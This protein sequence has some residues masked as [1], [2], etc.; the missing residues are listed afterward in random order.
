MNSNATPVRAS[1]AR[2]IL[3]IYLDLIVFSVPWALLHAFALRSSPDLEKLSTPAKF[4]TFAVLE[5][6]LHRVVRWSP[7]TWLLAIRPAE[8]VV[9]PIIKS[10]E[11]WFTL[12]AGVL[13]L[14]EGSKGLVRWTMWTPPT[15]MFG[16]RLPAEIWPLIAMSTG[17]VECWIAYLIFRTRAAAAAVALPYFGAILVSVFTSWPLWDAWVAESISRR[18]AYQGAAIRPG[19]IEQ[20]QALS[21]EIILAGPVL[22]L[23]LTLAATFLFAR[24]RS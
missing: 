10:R 9:D 11:H 7:G 13:L 3:A 22:Y 15:P 24:R 6:L 21:P 23:V 4:I 2:L 17:A 12:L 1:R 8:R 16:V 5:L 19:E 18:R 20:A 14:L